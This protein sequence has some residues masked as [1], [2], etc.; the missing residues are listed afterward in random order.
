M[1]YRKHTADGDYSFGRGALD[2]YVD[3]P[4]AVAQA[5]RT[6]LMLWRGEWFVDPTDGTPWLEEI[7]GAHNQGIRDIAIKQRVLGTPGVVVI[8]RYYSE[9][10]PTTRK[11]SVTMQLT[12]LYGE[13]TVSVVL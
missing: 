3:E 1:R 11:F 2:F 6:R 10:D 9:L 4:A 8:T 13:T 5:V 12:T 7:T